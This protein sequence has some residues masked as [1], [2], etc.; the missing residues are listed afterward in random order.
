[1]TYFNF[2]ASVKKMIYDGKLKTYF[3][4]DFY[5]N[6]SPALI[7]VFNDARRPVVPIRQ[8]FWDEYFKLIEEFENDRS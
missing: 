6:I 2:H 5:K 8:R 1:M 7:L 4:V 3:I